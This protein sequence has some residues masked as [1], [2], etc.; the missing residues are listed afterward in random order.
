MRLVRGICGVALVAAVAIG[1]TVALAATSGRRSDPGL[2][3]HPGAKGTLASTDVLR[4]KV[5]LNGHALPDEWTSPATG[6]YST[7][8]EGT[9]YW[10]DGTTALIL[11]RPENGGP[12]ALVHGDHSY[13]RALSGGDLDFRP[14]GAL[15][16]AYLAKGAHPKQFTAAEEDGHTVL[17]LHASYPYDNGD[18][19]PL[20]YRVS[21]AERISL[22]EART[23]GLFA[24][25]AK[26]TSTSW[27]SRPGA[28]SR[29][30]LA[31]YWL[32]PRSGDHLAALVRETT[33]TQE[34]PPSY[35]VHYVKPSAACGGPSATAG[36][37]DWWPGIPSDTCWN[38]R[39]VSSAPANPIRPGE[40]VTKKITLADGTPAEFIKLALYVP[41]YVRTKDA[42]IEI[43]TGRQDPLEQQLALARTLRHVT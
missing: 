32:G 43:M 11:A 15:V 41:F 26:P 9:R 1:A 4:L 17:E 19:A 25:K 42:L 18:S 3:L 13:L 28:S 6:A 21:V 27:Q 8:I 10:M 35:L 31:V 20:D 38:W 24:S 30:G 39:V 5:S 12:R 2:V 40:H 33:K 29:L 16:G 23:R 36:R 37:H 34:D 7:T 14:G 22:S